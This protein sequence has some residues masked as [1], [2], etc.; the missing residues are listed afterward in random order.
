MLPLSPQRGLKTQNGVFS[1]K[2]HF[3]WRK[4]A[5]KFLCVKTVSG[6]VV[7][8][9]LAKLSMQKLLVGD[10]PKLLPEILGQSDRGGAQSPIFD[11]FSFVVPHLYD[12][13]KKVQLTLLGSPLRP[14][15]PRWTIGHRTL[16]LSPPKGGSKT[17]SVRNLNNKLQQ[18]RNGTR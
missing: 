5:T 11:L 8:H 13:S 17:Q 16:S 4:S 14:M 6:K 9:S 7:G 2:S 10:V 12:L 15:S 3:T 1:L 18:F